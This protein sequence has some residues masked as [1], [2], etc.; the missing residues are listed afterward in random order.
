MQDIVLSK[1]K[2]SNTDEFIKKA[3]KHL[4]SYMRTL[5]IVRKL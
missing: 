5:Y 2:I 4:D 3:I 1:R